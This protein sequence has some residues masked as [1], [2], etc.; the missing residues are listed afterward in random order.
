MNLDELL[1][2]REWRRCVGGYDPVA[3]FAYFC[4]NYWHIK[5]PQ[6]VR[7]KFDLRDAQEETIEHWMNNRYSVVLKA[8]QIGFSTVAAAYSFWL[9]FFFADRFVVMLSRTEREAA[10]LL[11]K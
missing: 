8:R 9:T 5:H 10:K 1:N 2:E 4:R 3:G 6:D 7:I 11:Q